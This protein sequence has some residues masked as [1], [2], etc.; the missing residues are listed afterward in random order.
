MDSSA[1]KV[2]NRHLDKTAKQIK[3]IWVV[4]N[5]NEHSAMG[6]VVSEVD[7]LTLGTLA[8]GTGAGRWK[9]EATALFDDAKSA[10][11]DA[12]ERFKNYYKGQIPEWVLR[13]VGGEKG[14]KDWKPRRVA[15]DSVSPDEVALTS[16]E[17]VSPPPEAPSA[18]G[19]FHLPE[20]SE[21]R[22]FAESDANT[23]VVEVAEDS[24]RETGESVAEAV[25]QAEDGPPTPEEIDELPGSDEVS[26]LNR[27]LVEEAPATTDR[28]AA[29]RRQYFSL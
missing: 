5:P 8:I 18:E 15:A 17:L 14:W 24:A 16:E 28:M 19:M 2:A 26:T 27:F 13:D 29:L 7:A 9:H 20:S 6:D 12:H 21:V 10:V 23:N 11:A 1:S 22:E 3:T 25:E 4:R